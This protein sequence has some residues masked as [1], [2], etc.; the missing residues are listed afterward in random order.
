MNIDKKKENS[1]RR[2]S[3]ELTYT[4]EV[5]LDED[6]N[7]KYDTNNEN[8]QGFIKGFIEGIKYIQTKII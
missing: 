4:S 7:G 1:I 3:I 5:Y 6:D 2:I 8:R